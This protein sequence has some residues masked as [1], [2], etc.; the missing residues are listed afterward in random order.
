[1]HF[2][3]VT[4]TEALGGDA[5]ALKAFD[6][7]Q[8]RARHG[9]VPAVSRRA[10]AGPA[11][12]RHLPL[13]QRAGARRRRPGDHARGEFI[14]RRRP[15]GLRARRRCCGC[16]SARS[17]PVAGQ[18]RRGATG[19]RVGYVPAGRDRQLELPG[20]GRRVRAHGPRARRAPAV[21]EPGRAGARSRRCSTR[22]GIGDLGRPPHPRALR[23]PAAA[24]LHRPRAARRARPAAAR[25]ADLG[26]RRAHPPRDPAPARRPQRD[27]PG[28]RA[29]D[30][31]PQRDRRAPAAPRLPQP[32]RS[33]AAGP[34]REVLTA[35][36][37]RA[38]L[39]R[40]M[41]V[42]EHGG[43][44]R[45]RRPPHATR[46]T[47]VV[48]SRGAGS[49]DRRAAAT[50]SSSS[51]SATGWSSRRSPARCAASSASTSCSRA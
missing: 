6:A 36:R 11:R 32:R 13:R 27:G 18:R 43:M 16:C 47:S 12:R 38:D 28:D 19:L 14:G 35:G 39:R 8:R 50:R 20:H 10:R 45:R 34:P 4:M 1:M 51:S 15:V 9:R 37:P 46:I 5:T 41:E 26:R 25:R 22:L 44:P 2:D 48:S 7:A 29:H 23:R 40:A 21:G 42:L 24:R 33:S 30:P 31:R 17:D 49:R 3:Y